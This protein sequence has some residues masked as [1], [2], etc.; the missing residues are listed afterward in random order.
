M[1]FV[2]ISST[3]YERREGVIL[4]IGVILAFYQVNRV[5]QYVVFITFPQCNLEPNSQ[6]Y[7]VKILSWD[8]KNELLYEIHYYIYPD[9]IL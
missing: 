1:Y 4:V 3:E 8:C 7:P 6:K 9:G 5:I 2:K